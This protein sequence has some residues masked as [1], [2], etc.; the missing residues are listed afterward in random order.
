MRLGRVMRANQMPPAR[1]WCT[2][3][4][5]S[6]NTQANK[7]LRMTHSLFCSSANQA[8]TLDIEGGVTH[9]TGQ[10]H[11]IGQLLLTRAKASA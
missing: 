9:V 7:N 11:P 10:N 1:A 6:A 2:T 5:T 3:V 4:A 8:I